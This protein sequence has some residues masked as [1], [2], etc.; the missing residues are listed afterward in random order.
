M[1]IVATPQES[2]RVVGRLKRKLQE[3]SQP[4]RCRVG[5]QGGNRRDE[6][7]WWNPAAGIWSFAND[8]LANRHWICF[9]VTH[10]DEHASPSITVEINIPKDV[11]S[12]SIA[13]ALGKQGGDYFLTHSGRIGGGKKGVSKKAFLEFYEGER[14]EIMWADGQSTERLV[15][16]RIASPSFVNRLGAFVHA[17]D[18]FKRTFSEPA[19]GAS[20]P[21][22]DR[23][24][25]RPEFEGTR[26][27]KTRELRQMTRNHGAVVRALNQLLDGELVGNTQHLDLF[28]WIGPH[29]KPFVFEV[30]TSTT[31]TDVYTGVGQLLIHAANWAEHATKILVLPELP[32]PALARALHELNIHVLTFKLRAGHARFHPNDAFKKLLG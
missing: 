8:E 13:G 14:R 20:L 19:A 1:E 27:Y 22:P 32:G 26:T 2:R 29:R 30:K 4:F 7:V 23:L 18:R 10:P 16:G 25:F 24:F 31:T 9:G 28:G 3:G 17:V 11:P 6:T 5:F 15:I 21:E 12:R